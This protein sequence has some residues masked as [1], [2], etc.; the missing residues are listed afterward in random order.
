MFHPRNPLHL[1]HPFQCWGRV[2][3]SGLSACA[4]VIDLVASGGF[5]ESLIGQMTAPNRNNAKC[6]IP[7]PTQALGLETWLL[8]VKAPVFIPFPSAR[9]PNTLWKQRVGFAPATHSPPSFA[10]LRRISIAS[11]VHLIVRGESWARQRY[12]DPFP[13]RL[14][15]E[16]PHGGILLLPSSPLH[17][18]RL[19]QFRS[20]PQNLA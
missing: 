1:I 14:L 13:S 3:C 16:N 9:G 4:S 17:Q 15:K 5:D 20:R 7:M 18:I 8:V 19:S 6:A 12:E 11:L 2:P 10:I